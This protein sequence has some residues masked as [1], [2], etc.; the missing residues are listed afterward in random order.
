[1]KFHFT[2]EETAIRIDVPVLPSARERTSSR[3]SED[4]DS[5]DT[6]VT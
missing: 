5:S 4:D 1:M 6:E 2:G 3:S